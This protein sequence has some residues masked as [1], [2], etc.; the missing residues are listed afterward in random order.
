MIKK[1]NYIYR[2]AG[3]VAAVSRHAHEGTPRSAWREPSSAPP[4]AIQN[5]SDVVMSI[6]YP[7]IFSFVNRIATRRPTWDSNFFIK[8]E[9]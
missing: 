4:A 6:I 2:A 3:P 5:Y 8:G 7:N 1:T 9:N